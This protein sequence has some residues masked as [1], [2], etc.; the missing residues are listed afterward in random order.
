MRACDIC[1]RVEKLKEGAE[2][3][4]EWQYQYEDDKGAPP[5]LPYD[6]CNE[7]DIQDI[8]TNCLDAAREAMG[9]WL[10]EQRNRHKQKATQRGKTLV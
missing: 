3:L 4:L 1:G 6:F 10:L 8:C 9:R 5:G 7:N 2:S